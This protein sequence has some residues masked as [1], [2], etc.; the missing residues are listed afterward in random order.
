MASLQPKKSHRL[1]YG[2]GTFRWHDSRGLWVGRLEAGT[3]HN[4]KRRQ[5]Q[6]T[7]RDEDEAWDKLM[8]KR[9]TL[10]VEGAVAALQKDITVKAWMPQ[11][12][13]ITATSLRPRSQRAVTSYC[14]RWIVPT[15]G[16]RKLQDLTAADARRLVKTVLDAGLAS[17]TAGKILETLQ[18]ALRR[19]RQD[20][21]TVPE[22]VLM[23]EKPAAAA[24][25][26]KA[27][28]IDDALKLVEHVAARPDAAR[29]VAALL[30][31]MRPGECLGLT[32]EAVDLERGELDVSWQ[33]QALPYLDRQAQ[34]F[35]VPHGYEARRLDG[36]HHLVRPKTSAGQRVIP[37]VPWLQNSLRQW[38]EVA[39]ESRHGLVWPR[40]DGRPETDRAD[41]ERWYSLQADAGVSKPDGSPYVLYEARHTAASLLLMAG[42]DPTVIKAIMGHSD[43]IAQEAYKHAPRSLLLSALEG[44]AETLQL[45]Q[46][47]T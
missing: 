39:P 42:V 2:E 8:V 15:L 5:V 1:R 26:R 43:I 20:G 21:Y 34:T 4:G 9:K 13:A 6:V 24:V 18:A 30:Q 3:D 11:W 40:P 37:L 12:L 36:A 23:V 31:G 29:W 35:R 22:P 44:V 28:P 45:G 17:T 7:S 47:R 14:T 46:Q 27:I 19:A 10:M 16:A 25:K 41:R 32:W 33:L 38:R